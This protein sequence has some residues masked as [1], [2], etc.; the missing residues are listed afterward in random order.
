MSFV[1]N[2]S[3]LSP[4]LLCSF[5]KEIV[6][7]YQSLRISSTYNYKAKMTTT[8]YLPAFSFAVTLCHNMP[9]IS[10]IERLL[11]FNFWVS[12]TLFSIFWLFIYLFFA[13]NVNFLSSL[14]SYSYLSVD[15]KV[16]NY[17]VWNLEWI[18]VAL[19]RNVDIVAIKLRS[20]FHYLQV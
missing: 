8:L 9:I 3:V 16:K 17:Y 5:H 15:S 11:E 7:L 20:E 14:N 1:L 12:Y 19:S 10:H 13:R 2:E 18:S 6:K 4:I